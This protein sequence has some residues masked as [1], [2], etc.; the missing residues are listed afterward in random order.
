MAAEKKSTPK[1]NAIP[2]TSVPIMYIIVEL[3]IFK[4]KQIF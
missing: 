4:V 1:I 2:K 3:F